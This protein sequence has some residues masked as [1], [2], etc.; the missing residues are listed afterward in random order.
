[1]LEGVSR[2][3]YPLQLGDQIEK[4]RKRSVSSPGRDRFKAEISAAVFPGSVGQLR[5]LRVLVQGG[6]ARGEGLEASEI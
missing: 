5:Y 3:K 4:K 2:Y 1:M 6:T